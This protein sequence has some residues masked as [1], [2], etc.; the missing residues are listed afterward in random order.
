M[1]FGEKL[2]EIRLSKNLTQ[3]ELGDLT[4]FSHAIISLWENREKPPTMEK[5]AIL[6]T[7]LNTPAPYFLFTKEEIELLTSVF[8]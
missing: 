7:A 3:R 5:I 4:G 1:V 2:K 8:S 6:A